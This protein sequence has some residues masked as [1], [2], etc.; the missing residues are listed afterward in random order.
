MYDVHDAAVATCFI[1]PVYGLPWTSYYIA[2]G[3][4]TLPGAKR[5]TAAQCISYT[6]FCFIFVGFVRFNSA[7]EYKIV[8]VIHK[9]A[10]TSSVVKLL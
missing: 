9:T 6:A 3:L 2:S 1:A 5:P 4:E 8:S 7:N 10:K